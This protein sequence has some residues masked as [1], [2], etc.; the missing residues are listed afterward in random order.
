M[1][2]LLAPAVVVMLSSVV[3]VSVGDGFLAR[4]FR[5]GRST[6]V[7]LVEVGEVLVVQTYLLP[8]AQMTPLVFVFRSDGAV[9]QRISGQ[10]F[11]RAALAGFAQRLSGGRATT[12]VEPVTARQ[13]NRLRPGLVPWPVR[14]PTLAGIALGV[15]LI[16]VLLIGVAI[17]DG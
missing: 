8:R 14:Y 5:S 11:D 7:P 15:A 2:A 16:V 9:L 12:I 4:R 13:L 1:I 17:L 3:R 10:F 6:R